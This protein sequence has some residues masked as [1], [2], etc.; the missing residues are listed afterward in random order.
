VLIVCGKQ[1]ATDN[2]RVAKQ[3]Y[4]RRKIKRLEHEIEAIDKA[5]YLFEQ[6]G[7]PDQHASMLERKRDDMIR[8][9]VLQMH[10]SIEDV[11]NQRIMCHV[12]G[13]PA[14][15]RMQLMPTHSGK[16]LRKLLMSAEGLGFDQKLDL[17]AAL[18]IISD[19]RRKRLGIL[20][21]LRNKCSHFWLLKAPVRKGRRP[22]QQKP[23]LLQYN[24]R[25]LHQVA[26]FKD[27]LGEY[28]PLYAKMFVEYISYLDP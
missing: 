18:R 16:A 8:A 12:L 20:N 25:D 9:A 6:N 7:A 17:A 5:F 11:L 19:K 3:P 10:T 4:L 21:T 2:M 13:V 14:H 28:G 23:P 15:K 26:T 24:G 1:D 22:R 27:L